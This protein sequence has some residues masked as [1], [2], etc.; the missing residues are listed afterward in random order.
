MDIFHT[1]CMKNKSYTIHIIRVYMLAGRPR[2]Y[3]TGDI[4][5]V[6]FGGN[7]RTEI[8]YNNHYVKAY[9][10]WRNACPLTTRTSNKVH[11]PIIKKNS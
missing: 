7:L 8:E 10:I 3:Y 5:S 9:L 4:I 11:V 6:I 1:K 2:L